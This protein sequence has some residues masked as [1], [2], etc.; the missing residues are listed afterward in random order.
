[1]FTYAQGSHSVACTSDDPV[2]NRK[3]H[4]ILPKAGDIALGFNAVPA[5]DFVFNSLRY[6]SIMGN[7]APAAVNVAAPTN[8]YVN[9]SNNQIVAKYYLEDKAAVRVKIGFNTLSG[10]MTNRVQDAEAMYAASLGTSEDVQAASLI[11]VEDQLKYSKSNILVTAGYEMRRGYRRLQGFYGGE[12]GIGGTS[13]RQNVTYG[14]AFSDVYAVQYTTNFNAFNTANQ[15]PTSGRTVRNLYTKERGGV[16]FGLRG[17]I[18]IE[19]F[20]FSKISIS[21]EYGWGYSIVTRRGA[22]STQE[23]FVNGQNGPTVFQE[24]VNQDNSEKT[25][26]FSVDNNAANIFSMNN[27]L[28]G[29]TNLSGG[30]G[31]I[32]LL[33]HF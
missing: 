19:Y 23:V 4:A 15:L 31:A 28:G 9:G 17:F 2:L 22:K 3:G 29:N 5:L 11:R 33:F 13:M 24:E 12:I 1:M 8:A 14:N 20:V 7:S 18:G 26:G 32:T 27:T 16:R 25:K 6:V 21:A 30:A 10:R